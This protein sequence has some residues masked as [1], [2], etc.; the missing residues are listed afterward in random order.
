MKELDIHFSTDERFKRHRLTNRTNRTSLRLSKYIGGSATFMKMKSRLSK[1]LDH[2]ATLASFKYTHTL[3]TNKDRFADEWCA[4]HYRLEAATQQSRPLS[5]DD[6]DFDASIVDPDR[7]EQRYN[8]LLACVGETIA[9]NSELMEKLERLERLQEQMEVYNEKMCARGSS[10][11]GGTP[12][13]EPTLSPQ[14][15]ED[16]NDNDYLDP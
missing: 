12:T 5:R 2:E 4:A 11:T 3:K 16:D 1:S 10:A 7:S 15:G 13:S 9:N 8:K 14:K 6:P